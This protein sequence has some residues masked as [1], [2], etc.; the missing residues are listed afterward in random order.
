MSG[1]SVETGFISGGQPV[2][3]TTR[4]AIGTAQFGMPYG[5]N[6]RSGIVNGQEVGRILDLAWCSGVNTLET[7]KLYGKA[8]EQIGFYLRHQ[9]S[10]PWD[11][12]TKLNSM[13]PNVAN[14]IEDSTEKLSIKPCGVLAHSADLFIERK[15]QEQLTE[16]KHE[17]RIQRIGVSLY[18]E[19]EINL[20]MESKVEPDIIQLPMNILDTRLHRHGVLK[21]LSASGVDVHIRSVFLQGLF[22]L[23]QDILRQQFEDAVPYLGKLHSIARQAGLGLGEL[24]LLWVISLIEVEKVLVGIENCFQLRQHLET[25]KKDVAPWVF[26]DALSVEYENTNILNPSLWQ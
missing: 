4:L 12:I 25:L 22:F 15:F 10:E 21:N 24:S 1:A 19:E 11:V 2:F 8:E 20:V 17:H 6:N 9:S 7:A 18:T 5:I 14:Q 3:M 26:E 16:A 13:Q 23:P